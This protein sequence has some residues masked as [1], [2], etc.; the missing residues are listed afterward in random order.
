VANNP[1]FSMLGGWILLMTIILLVYNIRRW[2][3]I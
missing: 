1:T 2:T 3:C